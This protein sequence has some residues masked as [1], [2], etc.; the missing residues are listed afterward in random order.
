MSTEDKIWFSAS[1]IK[2]LG[3]ASIARLPSSERGARQRMQ[4]EKWLSRTVPGK[5]GRGGLKTEFQP[6]VEILKTI[7]DFLDKNPDFFKEKQGSAKE[8]TNKP[9]K[10]LIT[11]SGKNSGLEINDHLPQPASLKDFV[12]VPQYDVRASAGHGSLIHSE[13]IVDHLA[14][15]KAWVRSELD[16]CEKNLALITVKGDSM[17]PTLSHRDLI[18]IDLRKNQITDNAIYVL[19]Y[20]GALLVKRIQRKM[21]GAIIIKSDNPEYENEKLSAKQANLLNVLGMVVWHGRKM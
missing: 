3:A 14:F 13:Q 15:K 12:F 19:Q 9:S 16:C 21:D 7:H 8:Y 2:K 4:R 18:L 20:D 5:G 1:E 11:D 17:E 6:P 10:P